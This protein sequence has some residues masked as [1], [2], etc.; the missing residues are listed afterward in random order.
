MNCTPVHYKR[1]YIVSI[2]L[3]LG[4]TESTRILKKTQMTLLSLQKPQRKMIMMVIVVRMMR[5][6]KE[7]KNTE[8]LGENQLLLH[9][10][11]TQMSR[12]VKIFLH[13]SGR[14]LYHN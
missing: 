14:Q 10:L 1:Y 4:D 5:T 11:L 8:S 6:Q 12:L 13:N 9:L 7:D 2:T 3:I